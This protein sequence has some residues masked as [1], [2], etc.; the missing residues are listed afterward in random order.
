MIHDFRIA[1]TRVISTR[2]LSAWVLSRVDV[3]TWRPVLD[4]ATS[5]H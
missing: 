3:V 1:A 5:R 4:F 2:V